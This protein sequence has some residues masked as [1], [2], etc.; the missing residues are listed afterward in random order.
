[1]Q[2]RQNVLRM[3]GLARDAEVKLVLVNPVSS[4]CDSP[5]FKSQH[6]PDLSAQERKQWESL[7]RDAQQHLR[8]ENHDI[9]RA[10][11]LFEQ[12]CE[13]DPLFAGT[14][15]TLGECYRTV[16]RIEDA[17]GAYSRAK[18]V[19]VCPLRILRPM[20]EAVI[21]IA[22]ETRTP[23]VDAQELFKRHSPHGLVGADWLLDHVHPAIKGHQLLADEIADRLVALGVVRPGPDWA[24]RKKQRFQAHLDELDDLYF[25]KGSQRLRN[26]RRWARGRVEAVRPTT[27]RADEQR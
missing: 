26:V 19:D 27:G 12:A 3:V 16:G 17:R 6:R 14:W 15:Y 2:Y 22:Q 5:P 8:R 9:R 11:G 4:L 24:D 13:I 25:F 10:I 7:C 18:E 1:M 23:L 21:E 20:N